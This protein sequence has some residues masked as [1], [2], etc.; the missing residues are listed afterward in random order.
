MRAGRKL[1][2]RWSLCRGDAG[3]LKDEVAGV[4]RFPEFVQKGAPAEAMSF[5]ISV[6]LRIVEDGVV[7]CLVVQVELLQKND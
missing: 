6:E 1:Y 5:A 2:P 4:V 3:G 7:V